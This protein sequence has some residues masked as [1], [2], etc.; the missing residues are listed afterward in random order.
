M[1]PETRL[2]PVTVLRVAT[3]VFFLSGSVIPSFF[4]GMIYSGSLSSSGGAVIST[5]GGILFGLAAMTAVCAAVISPVALSRRVGGAIIAAVGGVLVVILPFGG[6][7]SSG[8]ATTVFSAGMVF[9]V[10]WALTRPFGGSGFLAVPI[11]FAVSLILGL[12]TSLLPFATATFAT[13]AIAGI[14]VVCGLSTALAF[15]RRRAAR[16][17]VVVDSRTGSTMWPTHAQPSTAATYAL[18]LSLLGISIAA[19]I[20]GH[21]AMSRLPQTGQAGRGMAIAGLVIGYAGIL[22]AAIGAIV[23]ATTLTMMLGTLTY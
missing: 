13:M 4:W 8:A 17:A 16:F 10:V 22:I 3:L 5:L 19:I 7:F 15:E 12:V 14:V 18:V 6:V 21:V 1:L 23:W 20:V 11:T 9:F 2:P